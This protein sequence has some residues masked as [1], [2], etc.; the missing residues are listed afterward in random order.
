VSEVFRKVG[1][2]DVLKVVGEASGGWSRA[3]TQSD[4]SITLP[5]QHTVAICTLLLMLDDKSK[6][7]T[8][9]EVTLGKVDEHAFAFIIQLRFL[10]TTY[11]GRHTVVCFVGG[12]GFFNQMSLAQWRILGAKPPNCLDITKTA[13]AS[14]LNPFYNCN[15]SS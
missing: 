11:C 7:V 1:L 15:P 4:R 3:G 2:K 5:L 6:K 12:Q 9:K 13:T 10:S 8:T 14:T